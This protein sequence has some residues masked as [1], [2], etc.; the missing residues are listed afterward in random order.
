MEGIF[1]EPS[2]TAVIGALSKMVNEGVIESSDMVVV[3]ITGHGLKDTNVLNAAASN[4]IVCPAEI[5]I[6]AKKLI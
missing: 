4:A 2:G 1:G 5:N 3:P 6:L